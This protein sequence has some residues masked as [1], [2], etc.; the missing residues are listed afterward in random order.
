MKYCSECGKQLPEGDKKYCLHCGNKLASKNVKKQIVP[1]KKLLGYALGAFVILVLLVFFGSSVWSFIQEEIMGNPKDC[2]TDFDC[3]KEAA[4]T[5]SLAT[6]RFE[7]SL[8]G[9]DLI[10]NLRVLGIN[11]GQCV[12]QAN[13][14]ETPSLLSNLNGKTITC[15]FSGEE[16]LLNFNS[17]MCVGVQ[18][19][20][21][22]II[23]T[24][25]EELTVD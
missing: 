17:N 18:E 14:D 8:M 21:M 20:E 25:I 5:C 1:N 23:S 4:E 12:F 16:D 13:I 24:I 6:V 11:Q 10:A 3:F 19:H 9:E 15:R 7:T 2:G 22:A